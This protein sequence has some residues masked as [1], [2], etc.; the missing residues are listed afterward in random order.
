[1]N[2]GFDRC[3]PPSCILLG[4]IPEFVVRLAGHFDS[5]DVRRQLGLPYL[6]VIRSGKLGNLEILRD[7]NFQA[8]GFSRLLFSQNLQ[9]YSIVKISEFSGLCAQMT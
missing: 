3:L 7:V 1:M 5:I 2:L 6:G 9:R 8:S 4:C